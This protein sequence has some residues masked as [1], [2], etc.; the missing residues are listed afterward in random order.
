MTEDDQKKMHG[1]LT[2]GCF[3]KACWPLKAGSLNE[4]SCVSVGHWVVDRF[5]DTPLTG[6]SRPYCRRRNP[7]SATAQD[8]TVPKLCFN[9]CWLYL[10]KIATN[11][12]FTGSPRTAKK[13]IYLASG[14]LFIEG[15]FQD[16]IS[17][18]TNCPEIGC[19]PAFCSVLVLTMG[20]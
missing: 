13:K 12:C 14:C 2:F 11:T 5:F 3:S 19:T 6:N 1:F 16:H 4:F 18:Y 7:A 9:V 10:Q 15:S 8:W 20:A 17:N